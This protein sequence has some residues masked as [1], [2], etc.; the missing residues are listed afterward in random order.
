MKTKLLI[1][2]EE[3][4]AVVLH[5][6]PLPKSASGVTV[7]VDNH[8]VSKTNT[9]NSERT[10]KYRSVSWGLSDKRYTQLTLSIRLGHQKR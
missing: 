1:G 5:L 4:N 2:E 9:Q 8:D 7:V 6:R 10:Y 3:A